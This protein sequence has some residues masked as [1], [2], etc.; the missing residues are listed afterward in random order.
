MF[1]HGIAPFAS[2]RIRHLYES[3]GEIMAKKFSRKTKVVATTAA[4]LVG[5]GAAFAYWTTLSAGSGDATNADSN[6]TLVLTANF[7]DGLAPG[8]TKSVTYTATNAGGTSSLRVG[9][10]EHVV[11]TDDPACLPADFTI[12]DVVSNTTVPAGAT[13]FALAGTGTL[14][15]ADTAINQDA[16]KSA[17]VVLTLSA[18]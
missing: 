15:F 7:T 17:T 11:T 9:T 6:G 3:L 14:T 18:D 12:P 1:P 4:L 13:N 16:C 2:F 8:G 10:I 5:G